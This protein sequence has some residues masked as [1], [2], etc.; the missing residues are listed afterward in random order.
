MN[1]NSLRKTSLLLVLSLLLCLPPFQGLAG[2]E[3]ALTLEKRE[4]WVDESRHVVCFQYKTDDPA[5]APAVEKINGAILEEAHIQE[6]ESLLPGV[7]AGGA[8]LSVETKEIASDGF[9]RAGTGYL[10]LLVE[11]EGKMLQ[12]PP[13]H[14][15]YPMVFRA[16]TGERIAFD[17][18]FADPEGARAYIEQYLADVVEPQ[19][20]TYLENS[21]LFPVPYESFG[22]SG[23]GH[24]ILYYPHD[25]LSFLSG[26]SGAVAFR[27]SELWDFL[28]TSE[29]GIALQMVQTG[30]HHR[31]YADSREPAEM[32]ELLQE[33]LP[34]LKG[35]ELSAPSLGTA[36]ELIERDY[37]LTTDSGFYPGGAYYETET[38]ELLGTYLITDEAESYVSGI[39]T[40]RVDMY[41]IETGKTT[42]SEAK[43]LLGEPAAETAV[44]GDMA[45]QYLVCPGTAARYVFT[46]EQAINL[47]E[48]GQT[49]NQVSLTVYAD[50]SG[51]VRYI[52]LSL[53]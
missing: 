36:M 25:Q 22:F 1:Y 47:G 38:P 29:T 52:R 28:D 50:E 33:Y 3:M 37:A 4:N 13:S 26:K 9:Y 2:E 12:G 15:Y 8:G 18:L 17:E 16:Q 31:Q 35:L 32:R 45:E 30:S 39:L 49:A 48:T 42:L 21:Q 43:R 24:L 51:M 23:E 19:L 6:Y 44:D 46:S 10:A 27:Y 11:A 5:L 14:R 53:E 7:A 34:G 41:G 40:S 20:S